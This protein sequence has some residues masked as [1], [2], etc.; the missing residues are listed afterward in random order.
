[1]GERLV[2]IGGDAAGMSAAAQAR[3]ASPPD[4]LEIV[5]FE[6]GDHTSYA[7][8]GLPY[9]VGG[10]V[11]DAEDLVTRSPEQHR[12]HGIDVR[13]AHEVVGIDLDG[14]KVS[15]RSRTTGA[16][17]TEAFDQLVIATGAVPIRPPLP[18]VDAPGVH[19]I[20]TIADGI[21]LR[22]HVDRSTERRA[23]VV[24]GGYIGLEMA[25]SLKL[26]GFE[27]AVV[28][29]LAQPMGTLDPDMGELVAD[30]LRAIGV[31][32]HLGVGV[33][34]FETGPD[35]QVAAV[36]TEAGTIRTDLVVLGLG[37][38]PSSELAEQAG[39]AVGRTGG[40]V[41]DRRMSTG[42]AGVWAAG[43]C[44]ETFHR[45][46]RRP[47]AIALGTHANKQGRVVGVNATGGYLAF[48]GVIGTAITKVCRYEIGR[49]G[50]NEREATAAGFEFA[51][52]RIEGSTRAHYYPDSKPII[53]KVLAERR[54]G[55]LLGA[56]IVGREGAAKRIDVM[57][58]AIWNG[59]TADELSQLDLGYAPPYSPV[60]D[61]ILIAARKAAEAAARG[62]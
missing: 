19:G 21:A 53:V 27:V 25:E 57:A 10:L 55:R 26:Q 11:A 22:A 31:E 50:L 42:T 38:R 6:R 15:V 13:L 24:G 28:E 40:I 35:G 61:S 4:R 48:P 59:M 34:G 17:T 14:R 3:R 60:W 52:A 9:Y 1:M 49:T 56:Q 37:V 5:V 7:A 30:A 62:S 29:K 46:S 58:A 36:V 44:V 12:A 18:G 45:V 41:T 39:I 20:Q 54:T 43:D 23:V 16:E 33:L 32:L 8:C 47:V 2:V 51:A